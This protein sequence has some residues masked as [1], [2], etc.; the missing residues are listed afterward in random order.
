MT[1]KGKASAVE[2][3]FNQLDK[4]IAGLQEKTGLHCQQGCGACCKKPDIEATILEFIPLAFALHTEGKLEEML[5]EI[6]Q[7]GDDPICINFS[8]FTN[9]M[10]GGFCIQYQYRGLICRLFGYSA[11]RDKFG[12]HVLVTCKLIKE[13]QAAIVEKI[14]KDLKSGKKI[15]VISNQYEKLRNID[16]NLSDEMYPI[17]QAIKKALEF[18]ALYFYYRKP[19]AS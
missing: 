19:K 11:R 18:V 16:Y 3:V 5:D 8:P 7:R 1:I 10:N 12:D 9:D 17:N 6:D 14:N 4:K 13:S 15:P 2:K